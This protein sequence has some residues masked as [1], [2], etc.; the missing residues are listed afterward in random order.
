MVLDWRGRVYMKQAITRRTI[1]L[2]ISLDAEITKEKGIN[3]S[4][5]ARFAYRDVLKRLR[6]DPES[7]NQF[8]NSIEDED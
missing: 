5:V 1:S 7:V 3:W 8:R 4:K 2:S 6:E